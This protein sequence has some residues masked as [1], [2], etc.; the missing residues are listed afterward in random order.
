[1]RKLGG[2]CAESH[3]LAGLFKSLGVPLGGFCPILLCALV[4]CIHA[5]IE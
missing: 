5:G 4:F 2:G 3:P 1:M